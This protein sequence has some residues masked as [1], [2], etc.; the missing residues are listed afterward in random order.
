MDYQLPKPTHEPSTPKAGWWKAP[1]SLATDPVFL[2]VSTTHRLSA[3]G[4][5]AAATGW[6]LNNNS[7]DGWI[8]CDAVLCGQVCAAPSAQLGEVATELV[9]AGIWAEAEKDGIDGYVVA[10]AAQYVEERFARQ[11]SASNAGMKSQQ[12]QASRSGKLRINPDAPTD[13]SKESEKW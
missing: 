7:T 1:A 10:G 8:P 5:H 11:A 2:R 9:K 3:V 4:L 13:W 12:V 6:C